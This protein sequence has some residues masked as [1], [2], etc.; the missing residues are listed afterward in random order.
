ME[1]VECAFEVL[2]KSKHSPLMLKFDWV[3]EA[4]QFLK[5]NILNTMPPPPRCTPPSIALPPL[6]GEGFFG[7]EAAK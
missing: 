3:S 1:I 4:G 5:I 6:L 2:A 7:R